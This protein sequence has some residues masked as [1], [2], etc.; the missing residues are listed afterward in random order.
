MLAAWSGLG[1]YRRAR[2]LHKAAQFVVRERDG[3]IPATA[4]EL[5]TL[6]GIGEYTCAAIASIAF[7][8]S[9]A[10]VDGNVERVLLRIT[11]RAED[12]SSAGAA[13]IRDPGRRAGA[14]QRIGRRNERRRRPQPGHDGTGRNHLP[15]ARAALPELP[16]VRPVPHTRRARHR[17]RA[18]SRRSQ[19]IAY[20]LTTRN[21]GALDEVLLERRD[22]AAA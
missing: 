14:Q 15:A 3:H 19:P 12:A 13:F 18:A 21:R 5:R 11:G 16:R 17:C 9:I 1:Y 22:E 2:M 20:L 6:P 7:G 10:V 4:E 8:E